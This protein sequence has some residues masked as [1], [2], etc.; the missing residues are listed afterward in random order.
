MAFWKAKPLE[1]LYDTEN[2]PWEVN[3]LAEN[4]KYIN[5]LKR[6]RSENRKWIMNI[7]YAGF[8]PEG[9]LINLYSLSTAM[10]I[11]VAVKFILK[12]L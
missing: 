4:P 6:F 11:C 7:K 5:I 3:N 12:I 9:D 2:N 10:I 1:E 8:I